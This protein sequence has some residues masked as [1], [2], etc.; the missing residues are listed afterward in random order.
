ML[1]CNQLTKKYQSVEAVSNLTLTLEPG[2]IYALLGPNGSGKTTF[3]KM[4]AGLVKQ[5]SGSLLFEK[6]PIGVY[7][8]QHIAYMPTESYF[9]SYMTC[10][11][12]GSYYSDF[13]PDFN[14]KRFDL[15]IHNM[16]LNEKTLVSKLSSGMMA[17]LKIA[18]ALARDAK[19]VMLDE[20]LNG[21]DIIARERVISTIIDNFAPEKT[22]VISTHLVDELERIMDSAIFMKHGHLEIYGDAEEIRQTHGCS[23][24]DLYKQVYADCQAQ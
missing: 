23:I 4:A 13:F 22:F 3:M 1:E 9:Y 2:K 18:A 8:K 15:M 20:P 10:K 24:V 11:D 7:S 19:L 6:Q 14:R 5:S 16:E 21:I 17:K 12:V